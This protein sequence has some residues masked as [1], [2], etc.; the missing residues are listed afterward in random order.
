MSTLG[1]TREL[2]LY[3]KSVANLLEFAGK[4]L[5][6]LNFLGRHDSHKNDPWKVWRASLR[7]S[8]CY[9]LVQWYLWLCHIMFLCHIWLLVDQLIYPP[10]PL[11]DALLFGTPSLCDKGECAV[12]I[13]IFPLIAL[14]Y[15]SNWFCH[16][17]VFLL[18]CSFLFATFAFEVS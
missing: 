16:C 7:C 5:V 11:L 8:T 18:D 3:K 10:S 17:Y 15:T 1:T 9:F 2:N 13:S 12:L 14:V 6:F 4:N